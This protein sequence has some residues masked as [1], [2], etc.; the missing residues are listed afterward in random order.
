[1]GFRFTCLAIVVLLL[2]GCA[3]QFVQPTSGPTAKL[4][5]K[6]DGQVAFTWIH[7]FEK[8]NCETPLWFGM[9]GGGGGPTPAHQPKGML[10]SAKQADP[11]VV[12][13]VIP[14]KATQLLFTQHGPHTGGVV[15]SCSLA[16][17]F[18][19]KEGG[20][21]EIAYGFDS[22]HCF[23]SVSS[24]NLAGDRVVRTRVDDATQQV[25]R[26]IPYKF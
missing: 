3:G 7:T 15:R 19:A 2:S 6:P 14:A 13:M 10:D 24:L 16:L 23:A 1:M 17:N 9:M 4:R 22:A 12:E 11:N 5:I 26:C 20:E 8:A 18:M 25:G 21:Y